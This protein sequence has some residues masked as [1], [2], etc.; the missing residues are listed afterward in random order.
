MDDAI[1]PLTV[2]LLRAKIEAE[3]L[4]HYTGEK[5]AHRMLLPMG[6]SHNGSNRRSF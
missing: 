5:A 4:A 1:N 2:A 3:F 6:R